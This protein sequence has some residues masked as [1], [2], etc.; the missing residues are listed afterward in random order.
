M[1]DFR[2]HTLVVYREVAGYYNE[3]G[4]Y[5]PGT[6]QLVATSPCRYEANGRANTIRL[7]DGTAYTYSYII[8]KDVDWNCDIRYGDIAALCDAKG[9]LLVKYPIKV[10]HRGQLNEKI[11]V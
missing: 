10:F 3:I 6:L 5:V 2:P 11:W 1:V 4:D 9:N 8:Y 7:D